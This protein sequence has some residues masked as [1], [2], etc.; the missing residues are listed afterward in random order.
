[1]KRTA[2]AECAEN[3]FENESYNNFYI[4]PG[5]VSARETYNEDYNYAYQSID[6]LPGQPGQ[7]QI[8]Q[9]M[10]TTEVCYKSYS[11]ATNLGTKVQKY[12]KLYILAKNDWI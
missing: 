6:N 9:S 11:Y 7:I 8:N 2:S 3:D 10:A 5:A 1:M 12:S 4:R